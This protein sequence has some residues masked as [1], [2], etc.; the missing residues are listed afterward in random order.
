MGG[1]PPGCPIT[2]LRDYALVALF[3]HDLLLEQVEMGLEHD[4]RLHDSDI[5]WALSRIGLT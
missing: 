5:G 2:P 4:S 3:G 1:V